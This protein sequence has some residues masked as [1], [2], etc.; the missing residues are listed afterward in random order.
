MSMIF[1]VNKESIH[2]LLDGLPNKGDSVNMARE[3]HE[4]MHFKCSHYEL[5]MIKPVDHTSWRHSVCCVTSSQ[6]VR[7][8][9]Y[10]HVPA[11]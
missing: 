8:K 4:H 3:L 6:N 10:K 2:M 11:V 9:S 7:M 5:G 1:E